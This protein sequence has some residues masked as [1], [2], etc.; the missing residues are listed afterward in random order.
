[1]RFHAFR[2]FFKSLC[3]NS[4]VPWAYSEFSLGHKVDPLGYDKSPWTPEGESKIL[5]Q[6]DRLRPTLNVLTGKGK[7]EHSFFEEISQMLALMKGMDV[8]EVEL[9][10]AREVAEK[11]QELFR[12]KLAAHNIKM[13]GHIDQL[14]HLLLPVFRSLTREEL[15]PI[16]VAVAKQTQSRSSGRR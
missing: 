11:H 16:A 6:F 14:D 3:S 4:G 15:F 9:R 8:E 13:E 5:E 2:H 1:V 7:E 12:S 10:L